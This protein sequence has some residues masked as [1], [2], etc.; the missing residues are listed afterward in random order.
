MIGQYVHGNEPGHHAIYLYTML[1]EQAKAS[2]RVRQ[3]LDTLYSDTPDGIAGNEDAGQ[4][5]AWFVLSALGFY[6][7]EPAGA[8][9]WFGSPLFEEAVVAVP[10]GSFTVKAPGVSAERHR[11]ASARLNGEVLSR[12]YVT[13]DEIMAGGVLEFELI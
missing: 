8:R 2:A 9:F 4:M 10:G 11:I 13:Y 7:A 3:V 1:G 12:P 6:Q 5:S